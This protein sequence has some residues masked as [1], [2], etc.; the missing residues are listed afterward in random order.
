[1]EKSI[2]EKIKIARKSNGLTLKEISEKTQLSISFISQV[3]RSKSSVTLESLKKISEAIGLNPSYFF[4]NQDGE[5]KATIKRDVLNENNMTQN[6]FI[7]KDLSGNLPNQLFTPILV[8]LNPGDN[9][10]KPF[11]HKG[12][13]FI[14]VLEGIL[15][16]LLDDEE[17]NLKP[18]DCI[19]FDASHLHYWFNRTIDVVK[20]LCV[21]SGSNN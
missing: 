4:S 12:Q 16:I 6:S 14:Y 7:Y 15:S 3:E 19:H 9:R 10:G 1:M 5:S 17:Y 11:S 2:G 21:S 8:T 20:F 18:G 13:E